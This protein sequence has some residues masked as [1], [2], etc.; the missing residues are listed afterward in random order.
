M[1]AERL[2]SEEAVSRIIA[3]MLREAGYVILE[4]NLG[5]KHGVDIKVEK[6]GKLLLVEVEGNQKPRQAPHVYP[7]LHSLSPSTGAD[8]HAH[9][10]IPK[11]D[12]RSRSTRRPLLSKES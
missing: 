4:H 11:G 7:A 5:R 3:D 9:Y 10:G 6:D 2:L 1:R 8:L 12:L